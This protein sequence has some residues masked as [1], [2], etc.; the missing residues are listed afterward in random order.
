M[1]SLDAFSPF[2]DLPK[3][4][5]DQETSLDSFSPFADQPSPVVADAQAP[6]PDSVVADLPTAPVPQPE[7]QP[8]PNTHRFTHPCLTR[9]T[10]EQLR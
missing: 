4:E 9:L 1:N 10:L 7:S 6:S 2:A 5:T 3:V 8:F